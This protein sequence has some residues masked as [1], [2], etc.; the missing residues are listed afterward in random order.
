MTSPP[1][2]IKT[3]HAARRA[4]YLVS[5]P[6]KKR[7]LNYSHWAFTRS[8]K[9][10]SKYGIMKCRHI[11]YEGKCERLQRKYKYD[12]LDEALISE[13]KEKR[14]GGETLDAIADWLGVTYRTL[15]NWRGKNEDLDKALTEAESMSNQ[16]LAL[17][18][19]AALIK[20]LQSRVV[21]EIKKTVTK[22]A[23]GVVIKTQTTETHKELEPSDALVM[24]AL[25]RIKPEVWDSLA[26]KRLDMGAD[27]KTDYG[28]LI[29]SILRKAQENR[30]EVQ[31]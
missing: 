29:N 23:D 8:M 7:G 3:P 2:M 12:D 6:K 11:Q 9:K 13:I 10:V 22:D 27:D 14:A 4:A 18:A 30:H 19:T 28:D 31:G 26:V 17:T 15:N 16:R 24:F 1:S 25:Q 5:N 20:K 21:T